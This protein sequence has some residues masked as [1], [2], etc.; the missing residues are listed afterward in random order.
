MKSTTNIYVMV[1]T[2][3][4]MQGY[5]AKIQT[6][7]A[8]YARALSFQRNKTKLH[9]IGYNDKAKSLSPYEPI[10]TGG[11]PN[12]GEGLQYLESI[13]RYQRKYERTQTRSI[14]LWVTGENVLQGWQNPLESL[15]KQQG[16]SCTSAI[17]I[18]TRK[19]PFI[20]LLIRLTGFCA[21]SRKIVCA[22]LCELYKLPIN[23]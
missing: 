13:I 1:D 10:R 22:D 3:F 11:N 16:I 2:S 8:R 20:G 14:F 19:K 12:F 18:N 23:F 17:P 9:I 7:F 15:F 6:I 5:S 21:T 4:K